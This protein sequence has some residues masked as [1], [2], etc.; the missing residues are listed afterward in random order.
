MVEVA[1]IK[2]EDGTLITGHVTQV[3]L[4][5]QTNKVAK[6][7]L[8]GDHFVQVIGIG[9]RVAMVTFVASA[10]GKDAI[11]LAESQATPIR[12]EH[13]TKYLVGI[14][15]VAPNWTFH[16]A[17]LYAASVKILISEEGDIT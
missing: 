11:D 17:D 4:G 12:V 14:I 9:A 6:Q 15:E 16:R 8:S 1:C 5:Y 7:L 3:I 13:G 2:S 10:S